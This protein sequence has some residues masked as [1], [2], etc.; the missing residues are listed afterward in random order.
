[1]FPSQF[2]YHRPSSVAEAIQFLQNDPDAKILAG[3]HSLIPAMKLRLAVPSALVDLSQV[4]GLR[5]IAVNGDIRIGAMTTYAQLRDSDAL[6]AA[7]PLL[8]E[9]ANN[10][11]DPQV[12]SRGTLGGSLAH[13]DPAADFTAVVLALG[14]SVKAVGTGGEREIS[15]DDLFVDLFTT[16]LN[17]DEVITEVTIPNPAARTGMAYQKRGHPASGYAVVGVAVSVTVGDDGNVSDARIAVTGC[18]P[19]ATRATAAE[20]A[21][22]GKPLNEASI[23]A[24]AKAAPEG[25]DINGDHYASA[26]YRA[27]L[28]E[29][30][31]RRALEAAAKAL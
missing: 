10:V 19:K 8:S 4:D 22:V 26:E 7:M 30:D 15:A 18:T 11:G 12:Q 20:Q 21:L 5:G 23:D 27:H 29:V 6:K 28:V 24:A 14:G 9:V 17:P 3:G 2:D 25:L 1:M 13:A 31:T 16:S